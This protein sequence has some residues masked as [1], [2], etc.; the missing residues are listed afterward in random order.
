M[1]FLNISTI[2]DDAFFDFNVQ[3]RRLMDKANTVAYITWDGY[4]WDF[5]GAAVLT[6]TASQSCASTSCTFS[7]ILFEEEEKETIHFFAFLIMQHFFCKTFFIFASFQL[8][9][10]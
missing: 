7:S 9:N 4:L 10:P 1:I 2:K 6:K 5:N 3:Q 8:R